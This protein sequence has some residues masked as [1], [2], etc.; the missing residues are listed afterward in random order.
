MSTEIS[1]LLVSSPDVCGGRLRIEGTRI[2]INQI[3]A[4]YK[5][6]FGAEE[7]ADQYPNLTLAQIYAALAH[8]HANREE[9][10]A[11]LVTESEEGDGL[12]SGSS[13]KQSRL[14]AFKA[15][16]RSLSLTPAKVAAWQDAIR[17]ARR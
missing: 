6:G 11:D 9:I 2:S 17:D 8:Y 10:E 16:Q 4:L 13:L 5:Q 3:A 15:L 14:K 1:S 7:I 12:A